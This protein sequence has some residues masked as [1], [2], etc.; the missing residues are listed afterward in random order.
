MYRPVE[1]GIGI[2]S[3]PPAPF[4]VA[5]WSVHVTLSSDVWILYDRADARSQYSRTEPTVWT[6]PRSTVIHCGSPNEL[7]QRVDVFPSTALPPAVPVFSVELTVTLLC[8]ARFAA[9]K[10]P[11]CTN[12]ATPAATTTVAMR[13][14]SARLDIRPPVRICLTIHTLSDLRP[15]RGEPK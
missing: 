1:P 15:K 5:N 3:T 6:E 2:F 9:A 13:E 11:R 8:S 14:T 10:A 12:S 7:D 4:A